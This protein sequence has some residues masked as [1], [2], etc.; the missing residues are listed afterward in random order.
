MP[1]P[2]FI[3]LSAAGKDRALGITPDHKIWLW[4]GSGQWTQLPGLAVYGSIG[5]ND[6]RWVVNAEYANYRWNHQSGNWELIPGI[7]T[8]IDVLGPNKVIKTDIYICMYGRMENGS[9]FQA[10]AMSPQSPMASCIVLQGTGP[11]GPANI[12]H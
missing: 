8:T 11:S 6:E 4:D 10:N 2:E 5:Q 9:I 12:H 1:G 3:C 7:A